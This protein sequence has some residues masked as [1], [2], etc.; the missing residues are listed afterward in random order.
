MKKKLYTKT[1]LSLLKTFVVYTH[2]ARLS[3]LTITNMTN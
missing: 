1:A 3:K 2:R